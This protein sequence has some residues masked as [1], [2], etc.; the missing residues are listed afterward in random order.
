MKSKESI[1]LITLLFVDLL[2]YARMHYILLP[3]SERQLKV[4][5]DLCQNPFTILAESPSLLLGRLMF[6]NQIPPVRYV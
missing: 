1:R 5:R 6:A 4:D 3:G 2:S